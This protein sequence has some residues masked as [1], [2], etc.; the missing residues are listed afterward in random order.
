MT[1]GIL[2]TFL[3]LISFV[4]ADAQG[5]RIRQAYRAR[6]PKA[7]LVQ[8]FTYP[9]RVEFY[10]KTGHTAQLSAFQA[11]SATA[12]KKIVDDFNDNFDFCP[13]Y[14]YY[15]T[16]AH[17]IR[18][19]KFSGVLLNPAM[20]P[21]KNIILSSTD[22]NYFIIVNSL[23]ISEDYLP[24]AKTFA[25]DESVFNA[26]DNVNN[27]KARLIVLD[28]NFRQLPRQV[29]RTAQGNIKPEKGSRHYRVNQGEHNLFY[30][31]KA[32]TLNQNFRNFYHPDSDF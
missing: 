24:G 12:A 6:P 9:R 17:L 13:V 11:A 22:T 32:A 29:V 8:L 26:S 21:A 25:E 18:D 19:R 15:D 4:S 5:W 10:K 1:K 20:L 28:H 31:A 30:N 3:I 7:I 16:N 14:Y 27:N 23:L 2:T